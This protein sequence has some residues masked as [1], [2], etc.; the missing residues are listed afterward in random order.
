M[1]QFRAQYDPFQ[2]PE[3]V[4]DINDLYTNI[5]ALMVNNLRSG[6][7]ISHFLKRLLRSR[8]PCNVIQKIRDITCAGGNIMGE[9]YKFIPLEEFSDILSTVKVLDK[10]DTLNLNKD[11][12]NFIPSIAQKI[13]LEEI[14]RRYINLIIKKI[15]NYTINLRN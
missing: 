2:L 3:P 6:I 13:W 5:I 4:R 15:L 9:V 14:I 12:V 1:T 11:L 7:Y 10:T 8:T